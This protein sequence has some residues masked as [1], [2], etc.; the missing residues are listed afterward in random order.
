MTKSCAVLRGVHPYLIAPA[1]FA[2]HVLSTDLAQAAAGGD[3][4]GVLSGASQALS[5]HGMILLSG[6]LLQHPQGRSLMESH[7]PHLDC[8]LVSSLWMHH[9]G[10]IDTAWGQDVPLKPI[11]LAQS[12]Q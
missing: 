5:D 6:I 11:Q 12:A 9:L 2:V 1:C 3:I 10:V 4:H 7:L 8:S